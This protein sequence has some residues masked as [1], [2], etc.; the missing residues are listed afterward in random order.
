MDRAQ[1]VFR[2]GPYEVRTN[3]Q[4]VYKH[5]TRV[6]LRGQPFLVLSVLLE[7][8]GEVVTRDEIRQKLW[9]S[10]TF[11][12]FEHGL[13]T[14]I[15]KVRQVLC[16]SVVEP[17]YIETLPKIGYRFIASVEVAG[18]KNGTASHPIEFEK[19]RPSDSGPTIEAEVHGEAAPETSAPAIRRWNLILAMAA[20]GAVALLA[21]AVSIRAWPGLIDRWRN[22]FGSSPTNYHSVA[23]LPLQSLSA[24]PSQEYFA[25]GMTD[26][27]ITNFAQLGNLRVI[28]RT[29]AMRYKNSG[30]SAQQIGKELNVDALVEGTVERVGSRVRVRIQLIDAASDRHLWAKIYDRELSD[31][32]FLE[33]SV[34]RDIVE[35]ARGQMVPESALANSKEPHAVNAQAYE[36]YLKGRYFWNKRS[37]EGLTKSIDFFQQAVSL[38]PKLAVAYAGLAD[39]YSILG[40]DVL[41]EQVAQTKAREAAKQAIALDPSVAEGHAAMAMV[42]F[43]YDWDWKKAE[44]EFQ[45]A[46]RLNPNYATAHQWYSYYLSAMERFP[47]AMRE[48]QLAQE[49]DPLSLSINT[50]LAGEYSANGQYDQAAAIDRKV[51][52]MDPNF[53]PAHFGLAK[54]YEG[55]KMWPEAIKELQTAVDL[56]QDSARA[57]AALAYGLGLAGRRTEARKIVDSLEELSAKKYVSSYEMAEA[58]VAIHDYDAALR[59]LEK[60]YRD[61]ES[62]IPLLNVT[63]ALY[64]LHSD[65]RFIQLVRRAGLP[66][67]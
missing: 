26:E 11:V 35:E 30:K 54:V 37:S 41:P 57:L 12:D 3:S 52:E 4:E 39:A 65:P 21:L 55:K 44:T 8:A 18:P 15:K 6:K 50:T 16:D 64:P 29:S 56:S 58:L 33:S 62:Q 42:A 7:H 53:V 10:D 20:A 63:I 13:N 19:V 59:Y 28:S 23:V 60:S 46:L 34:A 27:I 38:D 40:S 31:V 51:L 5:G 47:E 2:F 49:L 9:A 48:A 14:S 25:D 66:A 17:R 67:T 45:A 32:L 61:H 22:A 24:D 43:Y 36:L 1:L